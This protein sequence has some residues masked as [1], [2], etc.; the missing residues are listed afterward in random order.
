MNA[1]TP[2][3]THASRNQRRVGSGRGDRGRAE[4][5]AAAD[6]VGDDDGGGVERTEPPLEDVARGGRHVDR[7]RHDRGLYGA[8]ELTR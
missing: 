2:P 6:D 8:G 4:E 1:S 7:V 3:A 5:N